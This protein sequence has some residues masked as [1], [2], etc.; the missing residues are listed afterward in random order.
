MRYGDTGLEKEAKEMSKDG[1][2]WKSN[3]RNYICKISDFT[4][5]LL[6]NTG[7]KKK[8]TWG[9]KVQSDHSSL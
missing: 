4:E 5:E 6:K 3:E 1:K 9:L 8:N 7:R 2:Q